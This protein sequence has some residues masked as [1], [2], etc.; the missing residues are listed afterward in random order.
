MKFTFGEW[1][2]VDGYFECI[3]RDGH[4][5]SYLRCRAVLNSDG[6]YL[7]TVRNFIN[8]GEMVRQH[9][10]T[11]YLTEAKRIAER[12]TME[13]AYGKEIEKRDELLRKAW[14]MFK[15]VYHNPLLHVLRTEGKDASG[16][17]WVGFDV[18]NEISDLLELPHIDE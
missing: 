18:A 17:E 14:N 9:P 10:P 7:P 1:Q 3:L 13:Y 15:Q 11:K 4:N 6:V 5:K 2:Y 16:N 8:R 12:I